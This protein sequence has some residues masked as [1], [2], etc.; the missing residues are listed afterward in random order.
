LAKESRS[1]EIPNSCF[2]GNPVIAE[3]SK[4]LQ[5]AT[6]VRSVSVFR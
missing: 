2:N 5:G 3:R 4:D 1:V 6:G